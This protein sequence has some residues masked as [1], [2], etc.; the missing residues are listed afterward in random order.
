MKTLPLPMAYGLPSTVTVSGPWRRVSRA[1]STPY[2]TTAKTLTA[3]AINAT[4]RNPLARFAHTPAATASASI[5]PSPMKNPGPTARLSHGKQLQ[6][7]P[8]SAL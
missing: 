7:C 1:T 4:V 3:P 8:R 5:A 2:E 6:S